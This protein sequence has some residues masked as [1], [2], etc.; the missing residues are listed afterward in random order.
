MEKIAKRSLIIRDRIADGRIKSKHLEKLIGKLSFAKTSVFGLFGRTLL[1]PLR[2]KPK[3][4]PYS[5]ILPPREIDIL[6]WWDLAI[7]SHVARSVE[8]KPKF[9]QYVI[10]TDA[11]TSTRMT[12]ALVF[13]NEVPSYRPV[14]DE[15]REEVSSP[16][17]GKHLRQRN[18]YLRAR[19]A[20]HR[21]NP[22]FLRWE[23]EK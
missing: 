1:I 4:R 20:R 7:T 17:L 5:E 8:I 3:L 9:P 21:R 2:D 16:H 11:A 10:Y 13:N 14:I 23:T 6:L 15:L 22:T 12:T 19:D 18:I